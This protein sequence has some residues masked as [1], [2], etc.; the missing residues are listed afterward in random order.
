MFLLTDDEDN[1]MLMNMSATVIIILI[2]YLLLYESIQS[3][4]KRQ[5]TF[6]YINPIIDVLEHFW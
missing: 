1:C 5:Y 6:N 3:S 4:D 2:Y